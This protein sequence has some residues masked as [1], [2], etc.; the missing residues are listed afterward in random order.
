MLGFVPFSALRST[1]RYKEYASLCCRSTSAV[2]RSLVKALALV[3]VTMMLSLLPSVTG[4]PPDL[5]HSRNNYV[6]LTFLITLHFVMKIQ[7]FVDLIIRNL[8]KNRRFFF[9]TSSMPVAFFGIIW[10]MYNPNGS[11]YKFIVAFLY[12]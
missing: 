2:M 1:L 11:G 3:V 5:N 8:Y 10:Y 6:G 7:R 12:A 9:L 4:A